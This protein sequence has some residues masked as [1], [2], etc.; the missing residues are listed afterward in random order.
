M[1]LKKSTSSSS[2]KKL[3][4]GLG[5]QKTFKAVERA[6]RTACGLKKIAE[7]FDDKTGV[8]PPSTAHDHSYQNAEK[9]QKDMISIVGGLKPFQEIPGRI[10]IHPFHTSQEVPSTVLTLES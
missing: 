5:A 10:I 6:T 4:K 8:H 2:T 3:L 1:I 9:D 7:N